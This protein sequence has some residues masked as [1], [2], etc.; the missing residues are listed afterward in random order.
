M[1]KPFQWRDCSFWE[2]CRGILETFALL[3][4]LCGV[5]GD[6]TTFFVLWNHCLCGSYALSWNKILW[7]ELG[8]LL[9]IRYSLH[10]W[11]LYPPLEVLCSLICPR[12][13][14][15]ICL[16]LH[17]KSFSP[18]GAL[19]FGCTKDVEICLYTGCC[20]HLYLVTTY[21]VRSA[22]NVLPE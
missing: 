6:K 18:F 10:T 12:S 21:F 14:T 2:L 3:Y 8:L 19:A 13:G 4:S 16:I 11:T 22:C 7:R 5:K 9:W 17:L 1:E 15:K 20:H